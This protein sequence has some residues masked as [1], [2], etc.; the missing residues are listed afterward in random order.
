MMLTSPRNISLNTSANA[1]N[2][3]ASGVMKI[4]SII[5]VHFLLLLVSAAARNVITVFS[6][7]KY[8]VKRSV[9]PMLEMNALSSNNVL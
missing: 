1:D 2:E 4:A 5:H 8:S 3:K 9:L 6:G 7:R